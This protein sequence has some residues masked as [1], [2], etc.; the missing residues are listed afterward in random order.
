MQRT[1]QPKQ[2]SGNR[3]RVISVQEPSVPKAV[4]YPRL[5]SGH[6]LP[7]CN[8]TPRTSHALRFQASRNA[9][10]PIGSPV[11]TRL[12]ALFPTLPL[13]VYWLNNGPAAG[14]LYEKAEKLFSYKAHARNALHAKIGRFRSNAEKM[15]FVDL[16]R[17][18][19]EQLQNP[20]VRALYDQA[21]VLS[22][23]RSAT[24]VREHVVGCFLRNSTAFPRKA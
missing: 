21:T 23:L 8:T 1:Y 10:I 22:E 14:S 7:L 9:P 4:Q 20:M 3:P 12:P 5:P 2:A 6:D 11:V 17:F 16:S 15:S 19:A 18:L 24:R 13:R